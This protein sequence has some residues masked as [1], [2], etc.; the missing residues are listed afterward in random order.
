MRRIVRFPSGKQVTLHDILLT[1]ATGAIGGDLLRHLLDARLTWL[2]TSCCAL[3][4]AEEGSRSHAP[5]PR[6]SQ[7]RRRAPGL[8]GAWGYPAGRLGSGANR[9]NLIGRIGEI[10]HVA[11]C[12]SLSQTMEDARRTNLL[13]T[14]HVIEFARAVRKPEIRS[15]CIT[16]R[17]PMYRAHGPAA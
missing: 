1:G 4:T 11:A 16:S 14:E 17:Q 7:S 12:T 3:K 15:T 9:Q 8:S 10:Y 13:G 2:F 6:V 5:G